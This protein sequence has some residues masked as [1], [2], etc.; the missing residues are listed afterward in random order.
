L[1][2]VLSWLASGD[3]TASRTMMID[4]RQA[5]A[6]MVVGVAEHYDVMPLAGTRRAL[7]AEPAQADH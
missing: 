1:P 4:A 6:G 7:L 2:I 5:L 3:D